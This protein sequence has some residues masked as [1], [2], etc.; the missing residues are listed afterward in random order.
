MQGVRDATL[1]VNA[2][3][4]RHGI[5][6]AHV[7]PEVRCGIQA[8]RGGGSAKGNAKRRAVVAVDR[9]LAVL[10]VRLWGTGEACETLRTAP[11]LPTPAA[12]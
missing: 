2:A 3:S 6:D 7:N 4:S 12:P 5:P 10:L 8:W 11:A 9:A 1:R